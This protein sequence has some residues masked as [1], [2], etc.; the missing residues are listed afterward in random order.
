M[1]SSMWLTSPD[2]VS[3]AAAAAAAQQGIP[4]ESALRSSGGSPPGSW[5]NGGGGMPPNPFGA[6]LGSPQAQGFTGFG[7]P[8]PMGLGGMA[9]M[10][11]NTGLGM[12]G[13]SPM[14]FAGGLG[15]PSFGG[16][17]SG[18]LLGGLGGGLLGG[19][20]GSLGG[21]GTTGFGGL[22]S[23]SLLGG[24]GGGLL[25][26]G[27]GNTLGG[28]PPALLTAPTTQPKQQGL[29]PSVATALVTALLDAKSA[30]APAKTTAASKATAAAAPT[31]TT[32][33][34]TAT[35]A[36]ADTAPAPAIS[37]AKVG[38]GDESILDVIPEAQQSPINCVPTAVTMALRYLGFNVKQSTL[39]AEMRPPRETA[40]ITDAV[41]AVERRG[42]YIGTYN[43]AKFSDVKRAL[44]NKQPILA[45]IENGTPS[46]TNLHSV[47]ITGYYTDKKT[48]KQMLVITNP[49]G[50]KR[51]V[52][53][54]TSFQRQWQDLK[55]NNESTGFNQ[56][57]MV[58]SKSDTLPASTLSGKALQVEKAT[59]SRNQRARAANG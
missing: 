45:Y 42:A 38:T 43:N 18:G 46:D 13:F 36:T 16:L 6:P 3:P 12:S 59:Y 30:K 22:G 19:G 47:L 9:P 40:S 41:K 35:R 44:D 55:V 10:T 37:T 56:F 7:P 54:Y 2:V 21:I 32:A 8:P 23:G 51:Q 17:G 26:G 50:G 33:A 14:P 53:S 5:L 15:A 4:L 49:D 48:G 57:M 39:D 34:T 24:L 11:M 29:D 58:L 25:G 27:L 28:I 1:T 20:L 52:M 31:T